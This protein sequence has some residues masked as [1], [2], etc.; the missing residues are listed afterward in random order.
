MQNIDQKEEREI[1]GG[2]GKCALSWL[3]MCDTNDDIDDC[4]LHRSYEGVTINNND[5]KPS[6]VDFMMLVKCHND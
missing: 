5:L 3:W 4:Q 1:E 6:R 2:E